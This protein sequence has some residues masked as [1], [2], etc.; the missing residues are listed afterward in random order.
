MAKEN[1]RYRWHFFLI[2]LGCLILLS[3]AFGLSGWLLFFQNL[4]RRDGKLGY[5]VFVVL[6]AATSLA[7]IP[8]TGMTVLAGL[9]FPPTVAVALSSAGALVAAILAFWIARKFA[10]TRV[11]KWLKGNEKYDKYGSL[12]KRH[13]TRVLIFLRLIPVFP[14]VTLN[15]IFGLTR[16]SFVTYVFW[17]WLCLLPGTIVYVLIANNISS[18]LFSGH[19][20]YGLLL[21]SMLISAVIYLAW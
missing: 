18:A 20:L 11:E 9:L 16:I 17:T 13:E 8:G 21:S 2:L 15:Y 7:L 5:A 19:I 1:G 12:I 10:R 3:E 14:H 6:Y 4:V